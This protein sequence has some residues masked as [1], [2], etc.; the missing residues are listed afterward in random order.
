MNSET[1]EENNMIFSKQTGKGHTQSPEP[2]RFP[3]VS[4]EFWVLLFLFREWICQLGS[5]LWIAID[6]TL[7]CSLTTQFLL[8]EFAQSGLYWIVS[9]TSCS[10]LSF[11]HKWLVCHS[12]VLNKFP[13]FIDYR[14]EIWGTQSKR[15]PQF[16]NSRWQ[17]I[18]PHSCLLCWAKG[19]DCEHVSDRGSDIL[20][21]AFK[22]ATDNILFVF[23]KFSVLANIC[24]SRPLSPSGL[25]F[26][27]SFRW[28]VC[29]TRSA[30]NV[31]LSRT[32]RTELEEHFTTVFVFES[33][34]TKFSALQLF[35]EQCGFSPCL[36]PSPFDSERRGFLC[37]WN[38]KHKKTKTD[39]DLSH[40]F[41]FTFLVAFRGSYV[42]SKFAILSL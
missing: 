41:L 39:R 31:V 37:V 2:L 15:K 24:S 17:K 34:T 16:A 18:P 1:L 9:H 11:C 7:Q 35:L 26:L 23:A 14:L 22:N 13:C 12:N 4:F 5:K 29:S 19:D 40:L 30:R 36:Y 6:R 8:F 21:A 25:Y 10:L 33:Q 38:W 32:S 27:S 3:Q 42:C 28:T 20:C